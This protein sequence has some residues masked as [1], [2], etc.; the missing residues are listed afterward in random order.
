[1]QRLRIALRRIAWAW[2]RNRLQSQLDSLRCS[3]HDIDDMMLMLP[4]Q[5]RTLL[6]QFE[7][8]RRELLSAEDMHHQW[9]ATMQAGGQP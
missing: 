5:R 6:K 2:R 1:M 9:R 8:T 7:A 3:I 4:A